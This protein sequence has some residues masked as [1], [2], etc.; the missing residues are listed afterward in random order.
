MLLP[1]LQVYQVSRN[2]L[3]VSFGLA[4]ASSLSEASALPLPLMMM[5]Y[6]LHYVKVN[7][8][9]L[10]ILLLYV[11][12]LLRPCL[13]FFPFYTLHPLLFSITPR[14]FECVAFVYILDPSLDKLSPQTRKCVSITLGKRDIC[15]IILS[16]VAT[17]SMLMS[18]FR[19]Y[20]FFLF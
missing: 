8:F 12:P 18:F 5:T 14:V 10:N 1:H 15:V 7:V 20:F 13:L 4:P 9:V 3:I 19:V 17:L 16:F 2:E 6:Q 11:F